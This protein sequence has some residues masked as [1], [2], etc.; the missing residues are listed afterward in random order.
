MQVLFGKTLDALAR[1]TGCVRRHRMFSGMSLLRTWVLTLLGRPAAKDRDYRD[2]AARLGVLVSEQ[3]VAN[4]FTPEFV[5]FL[6]E[7]LQ[8][9]VSQVLAAKSLASSLLQKFTAVCVGDSTTLSL[10]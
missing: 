5:Q 2:M 7:A 9:A 6:S 3:A 8:L 10:P 4:R 1:K